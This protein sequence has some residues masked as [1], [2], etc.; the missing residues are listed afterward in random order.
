MGGYENVPTDDI[1]LTQV[2]LD[3]V[4]LHFIRE[5]IA[6]VA[7]KLFSGYHTKVGLKLCVVCQQR[8][9][10]TSLIPVQ[11]LGKSI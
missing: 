4:W 10:E 6:P 2:G 11:Q 8:H 3:Q 7:L 9:C 1:H 5:Y